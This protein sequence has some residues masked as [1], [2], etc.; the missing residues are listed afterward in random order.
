ME[1]DTYA[2]NGTTSSVNTSLLVIF[3]SLYKCHFTITKKK[4]KL[5]RNTYPQSTLWWVITIKCY[6]WQ[7]CHNNGMTFR[8]TICSPA[9]ANKGGQVPPTNNVTNHKQPIFWNICHDWKNMNPEVGGYW[10]QVIMSQYTY[11]H[12]YRV[13]TSEN[14]RLHTPSNSVLHISTT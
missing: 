3:C 10:S 6:S 14:H 13:F 8:K 12:L 11:S 4:K 5:K 1:L 9:L 2:N 7:L